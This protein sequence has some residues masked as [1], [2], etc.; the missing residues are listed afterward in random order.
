MRQDNE[1][2][3]STAVM[4]LNIDKHRVSLPINMVNT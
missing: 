4:K 3:K 1:T 2:G